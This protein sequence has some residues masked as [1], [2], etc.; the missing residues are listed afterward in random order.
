MKPAELTLHFENLSAKMRQTL[1]R[2]LPIKI[3][4]AAVE[5]FKENFDKGGFFGSPWQRTKRQDNA[6]GAASAY[7]PLLSKR[8]NLLRSIHYMPGVGSVTITSDTPY[9]R[10][11]NEGL[12]A[13]RGRGFQ[14]PRRQFMGESRQLTDELNRII[15]LELNKVR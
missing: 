5:K 8:T 9:S 15:K 14:M 6:K 3:G 13:G 2:V 7:G 12:R 1:E 10:V 4:N 11:H